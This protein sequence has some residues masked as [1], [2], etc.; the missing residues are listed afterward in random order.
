MIKAAAIIC[1]VYFCLP[2]GHVFLESQYIVAYKILISLS[3]I[4]ML[5]R[6]CGNTKTVKILSIIE[7]FAILSNIIL[8]FT[9]FS[10]L[11]PSFASTLF[12]LN[13]HNYSELPYYLFLSQLVIIGLSGS[14]GS[15]RENKH[16]F[17]SILATIRSRFDDLRV[18]YR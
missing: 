17:T 1:F 15:I 7:F 16:I 9:P 10:Q 13:H 3:C 6:H 8:L 18:V 4:L 11:F 5:V 2:P 14:S 12:S